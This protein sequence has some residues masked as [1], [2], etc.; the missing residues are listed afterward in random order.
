MAMIA[1]NCSTCPKSRVHDDRDFLAALT[2]LA[3]RQHCNNYAKQMYTHNT[4]LSVG[5]KCAL[6]LT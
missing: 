5:H 3:E 2:V 6:T 4:F 1:K